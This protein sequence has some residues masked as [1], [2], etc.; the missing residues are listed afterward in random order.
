MF[1]KVHCHGSTFTCG[2]N[3]DDQNHQNFAYLMHEKLGIPCINQGF[4]RSSNEDTFLRASVSLLDA[5][6]DVIFVEWCGPGNQRYYPNH[7][8]VQ[9]METHE[10]DTLYNQYYKLSQFLPLLD[11]MAF[12]MNK[13]VFHFTSDL[14]IDEEFLKIPLPPLNNEDISHIGGFSRWALQVNPSKPDITA[15]RASLNSIRTLLLTIRSTDCLNLGSSIKDTWSDLSL[16][17]QHKQVADM[18]LTKI[19]EKA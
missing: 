11:S 16:V 5:D 18:C 3:L 14:F 8:S 4:N 1:K 12:K 15:E 17:D 9:T 19:A 7:L 10:Y 13:T 2:S 6:A